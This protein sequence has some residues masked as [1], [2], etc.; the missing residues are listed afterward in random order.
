MYRYIQRWPDASTS[1]RGLWSKRRQCICPHSPCP[2]PMCAHLQ[3]KANFFERRVGEYQRAGVMGGNNGNSARDPSE[4]V[5]TT[6][7]DF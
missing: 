7:A 2:S 3:G 1:I 5:F 6:E 4:Y